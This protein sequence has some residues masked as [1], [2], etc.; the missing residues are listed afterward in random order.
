MATAR[1]ENEKL[2][3]IG[4]VWS[5]DASIAKPFDKAFRSGLRDL[6]YVEGKNVR[7][8]AACAN[9]DVTRVR[10]LVE[11]MVARRVDVLVVG[12]RTLRI[13]TDVTKTVPIVCPSMGDPLIDG[14]VASLAQ[15]G[16]NVTGL[17]AQAH[18]TQSKRL[19]LAM[20]VVPGLKTL[21]VLFD[22]SDPIVVR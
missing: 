17:Y 6:G 21:G 5:G 19:E 2:P 12:A 4:E 9:G 20:E 22:A 16:G 13:A 18:E 1:G 14:L 15:P 8:L 11:E 3:T 7:I 10:A